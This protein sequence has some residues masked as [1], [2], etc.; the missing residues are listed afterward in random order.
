MDGAFV[1]SP[2][3][4]WTA[5]LKPQVWDL[6]VAILTILKPDVNVIGRDSGAGR[7][8]GLGRSGQHTRP[9]VGPMDTRDCV[10]LVRSSAAESCG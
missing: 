5:V 1:T 7:S 3:G 2:T 9:P 8:R 4:F 10:K 6:A